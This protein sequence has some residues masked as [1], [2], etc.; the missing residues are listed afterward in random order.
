MPLSTSLANNLIKDGMDVTLTF[1][2]SIYNKGT[3]FS[4]GYTFELYLTDDKFDLTSGVQL[5]GT[6]TGVDSQDLRMRDLVGYDAAQVTFQISASDCL[7]KKQHI[8]V[9]HGPLTIVP[10][11]SLVLVELH[12]TFY[13]F[14]LSPL[15]MHCYMYAP[16]CPYYIIFKY[17]KTLP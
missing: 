6:F 9:Y 16:G 1:D 11:S 14:F 5:P 17:Y 4:A 3:D 12:F 2:T 13:C 15:C 7:G 8:V 10:S